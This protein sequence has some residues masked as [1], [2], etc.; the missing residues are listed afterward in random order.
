MSVWDDV[1]GQ[2]AA[3]DLLKADIAS[4]RVGH[5]Y[6]FS[7]G[8][9]R[10]P[11]RA[12]M[13][14]ASALL[15]PD[16]GCGTCETCLRVAHQAHPDVELIE[17]AG[18]QLLVEQVRDAVRTAWRQPVSGT[19]RLIVVAGADRMNP[20]A[21]NAF[22][23]ALE[24]PPA[25]TVIVLLAAGA[26]QLLETVRSRC[27][28]V[29]FRAP[30]PEEIAQALGAQGLDDAA[31]SHLAR[32]SG[33]LE[34]AQ[35]LAAEPDLAQARDEL[36]DRVLEPTP[37]PGAALE[38]AEWLLGRARG[39]RDRVADEHKAT[40]EEYAD[41]YQEAK[42]LAD[43][44]LRREQRRAE[45]DAL[46]AALDDISSVLRDLAAL[47]GGGAPPLVNETI[48][49]RLQRRASE[50]GPASIPRLLT[51]LGDVEQARRRLRLNANVQLALEQVFLS[52]YEH[53][54]P[55]AAAS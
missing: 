17:P 51:C 32:I 54:R 8:A 16:G 7:G 34:R 27:R 49:P 24:E 14:F 13:A 44:R 47:A 25:S 19:R 55:A 18:V 42:G 5:A 31:A 45:Q 10:L 22:L 2:R 39:V 40:M 3:I 43:Q 11:A 23:K 15:C 4:G 6:L 1:W 28:E 9:G 50:L 33:T 48:G 30:S 38:V 52:V 12:A 26:D 41:W 21:Q 29:P 46:E 37:D 36:V 35:A 53:L 20:N